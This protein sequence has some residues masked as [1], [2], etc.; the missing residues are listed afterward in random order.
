MLP[1]QIHVVS[2]S[3]DDVF[4]QEFV[5]SAQLARILLTQNLQFIDMS[6]W[7]VD[8]DIVGRVVLAGESTRPVIRTD[9][10]LF[11]K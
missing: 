8:N 2:E 5:E 1:P 3:T 7:D 11:G 10:A 4:T 9:V 6:G